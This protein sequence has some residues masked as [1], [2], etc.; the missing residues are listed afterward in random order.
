MRH[1]CD[2]VIVHPKSLCSLEAASTLSPQCSASL[3]HECPADGHRPLTNSAR[4]S[5]QPLA[6]KGLAQKLRLASW[7]RTWPW[8][9]V[10][11]CGPTSCHRRPQGPVFLTPTSDRHKIKFVRILVHISPEQKTVASAFD[12][13]S[14]LAAAVRA[15]RRNRAQKVQAVQG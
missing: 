2:F 12:W 11:I 5:S 3:G 4:M 14:L 10:K 7:T 1:P 6:A 9:W 15:Q 13:L 8:G